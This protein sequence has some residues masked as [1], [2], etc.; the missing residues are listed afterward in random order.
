MKIL[1][2]LVVIFSVCLA[3]E[4]CAALLPFAFPASILAMLLLLLLFVLG[5][6]KPASIRETAEYL[7]GNMAFF[8]IPSG[9]GILEQYVQ[10]Q[11]ALPALLLICIVTTV[12]TFGAVAF[13]VS[14]VMH[15]M[16]KRG[17]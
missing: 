13:T 7:L 2:Q 12:L 15:L 4:L 14:A 17:R 9:V 16:E 8:F 1:Y 6:I 10:I 3:G 11:G 5:V